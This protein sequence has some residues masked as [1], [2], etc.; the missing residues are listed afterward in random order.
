[1]R[2]GTIVDVTIIAA[3]SSTQNQQGK[4]DEQMHHN[5]RLGWQTALHS[6]LTRLTNYANLVIG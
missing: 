6:H 5:Q 3:P 2:P 4:R 1:M